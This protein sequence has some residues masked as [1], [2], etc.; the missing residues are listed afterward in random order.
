M[1]TEI[2]NMTFMTPDL[3]RNSRVFQCLRVF[4]YVCHFV[5]KSAYNDGLFK[6]HASESVP[7]VLLYFSNFA[8]F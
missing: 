2:S 7:T 4:Q 3:S 8:S 5:E 1:S 6:C